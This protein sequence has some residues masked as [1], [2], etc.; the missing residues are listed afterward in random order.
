[1]PRVMNGWLEH[2]MSKND[3]ALVKQKFILV[4]TL[5]VAKMMGICKVDNPHLVTFLTHI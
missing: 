4:C 3:L 1:M 2:V 5:Q